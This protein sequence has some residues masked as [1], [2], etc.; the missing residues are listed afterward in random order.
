MTEK[1]GRE[2][3]SS[4]ERVVRVKSSQARIL[5]GRR[6]EG[7]KHLFGLAA[8]EEIKR[9]RCGVDSDVVEIWRVD[10]GARKVEQVIPG[11]RI[12]QYHD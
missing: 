9:A 6:V 4:R 11:Q 10:Q 1:L 3:C 7:R 2:L 8:L 12:R 5:N